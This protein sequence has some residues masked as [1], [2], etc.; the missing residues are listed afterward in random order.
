MGVDNKS[1][2][3]ENRFGSYPALSL[4]N[5]Q[6]TMQPGLRTITA[7]GEDTTAEGKEA[8]ETLLA[9]IVLLELEH[10]SDA[11]EPQEHHGGN[12]LKL[13]TM[14]SEKETFLDNMLLQLNSS[15]EDAGKSNV[16]MPNIKSVGLGNFSDNEKPQ[17]FCDA[18]S[19]GHLPSYSANPMLSADLQL[20][21]E[22]SGFMVKSDSEE[23]N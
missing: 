19:S 16:L 15:I 21:N 11:E 9:N 8:R 22:E 5:G 4:S 7:G 13:L 17:K 1:Y 3:H 20:Q 2:P 12:S 6:C 10:F 14:L 18:D 23:P